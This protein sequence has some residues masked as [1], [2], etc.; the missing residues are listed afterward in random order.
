VIE[1]STGFVDVTVPVT[2]TLAYDIYVS[3]ATPDG[4]ASSSV[5]IDLEP[6]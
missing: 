2:A 3:S 4:L 5:R 6:R 1:A